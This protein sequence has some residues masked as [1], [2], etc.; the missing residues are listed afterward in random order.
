[1]DI[2]SVC[3]RSDGKKVLNEM[4][5]RA[6]TSNSNELNGQEYFRYDIKATEKN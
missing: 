2:S 4:I 3:S 6:L 1:M 5:S